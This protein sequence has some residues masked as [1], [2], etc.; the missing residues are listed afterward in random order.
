MP[1]LVFYGDTFV[2]GAL[3]SCFPVME[4]VL[5]MNLSAIHFPFLGRALDSTEPSNCLDQVKL[6]R[7][8]HFSTCS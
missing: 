1:G 6:T 5:M 2:T 8:G 3:G 4:K 7:S